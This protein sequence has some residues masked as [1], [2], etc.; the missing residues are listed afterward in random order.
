LSRT[1][2]RLVAIAAV[3]FVALTYPVMS[4]A[5]TNGRIVGIPTLYVY[6]FLVWAALIGVSALIIERRR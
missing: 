1:G 2:Q 3:G 5:N 4:V 6:I